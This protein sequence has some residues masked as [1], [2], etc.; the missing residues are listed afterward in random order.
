[1]K[2]SEKTWQLADPIYKEIIAMP[3]ITEMSNGTLDVAKFKYYLEQDAH[4]LEYFG[5]CLALIGAKAHSVSEIL[6]FIKYSEMSLVGEME[7]HNSYFKEYGISELVPMSP[8]CHH[9]VHYVQSESYMSQVEV[10]M[11]AILPCFWIYQKVGTYLY[12]ISTTENNPYQAWIDT[13]ASPELDELV[14]SALTLI[15]AA[16]E[17][18]TPA[19]QEKMTQAFLY[20]SK[21]EYMFWDSAYRLEKWI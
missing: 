11:A 12:S 18:C 19:Q 1:M 10:G 13:Y 5:R 21:L 14:Q 16:A 15:D 3:F 9:Y 8:T 6:S 20:A 7:L 4:Y 2:W 17:K